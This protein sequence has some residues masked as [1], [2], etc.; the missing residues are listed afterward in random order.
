MTTSEDPPASDM[1]RFT[2]PADVVARRLGESA[3]LIRMRTSRIYQL[4]E[5]GARIWELLEQDASRDAVLDALLN[6]FDV[7][8][9]D[10]ASA[11]DDLIAELRAE[12]L[13]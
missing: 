12:G 4:N 3:V 11:L 13:L 6:E 1:G 10:A 7:S 8:R 5:T 9:E 2:R